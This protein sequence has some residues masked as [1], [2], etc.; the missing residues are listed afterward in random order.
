MDWELLGAV[1]VL[2]RNEV[3]CRW[4]VLGL[5]GDVAALYLHGLLRGLH[6]RETLQALQRQFGKRGGGAGECFLVVFVV[7]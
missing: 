3:K 7:A 2:T 1:D 4:V 6:V 5:A